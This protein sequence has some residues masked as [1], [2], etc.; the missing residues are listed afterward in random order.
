MY[1]QNRNWSE[2]DGD[3]KIEETVID[4]NYRSYKDLLSCCQALN[5]ESPG[6]W[7]QI[8]SFKIFNKYHVKAR[9]SVISLGQIILG[10]LKSLVMNAVKL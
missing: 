4:N 1:E 8:L 2:N 9:V 10:C 3:G 6:L 5:F 7:N